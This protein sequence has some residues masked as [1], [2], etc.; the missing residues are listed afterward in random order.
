MY[1]K[2]SGT[3]IPIKLLFPM[4]LKTLCEKYSHVHRGQR[5][6]EIF[7][8]FDRV[9][10]TSSFGI[11]SAIFLHLLHKTNPGHPVY[12]VDTGFHFRETHRFKDLLVQQWGLNVITVQPEPE[13]HALTRIMQTWSNDPDRCCSVNKVQPVNKLKRS[14]DLWVSGLTGFSGDK[15]NG[16]P[17]FREEGGLVRFYP[18]IDM[19]ADEA[20]WYSLIHQIPEHPLRARG[21][22]SVGC[23]HCTAKGEGR[24]GRWAGHNKTECGLHA[25]Q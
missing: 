9:L 21:Y 14:F 25:F 23:R 15:R 7:R 1:Q 18:L 3:G 13:S 22:G 2:V 16:K 8:D 11:N 24:E 5:M 20:R 4:N 6:V 19:D 10:V 12:F 17:M